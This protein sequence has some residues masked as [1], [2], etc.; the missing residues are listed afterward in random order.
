MPSALPN[1]RDRSFTADATPCLASGSEAV[2]AVV[3]GVPARPMP[4]ANR[5]RPA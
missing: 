1:S 4:T 5:A 2:I 3:A